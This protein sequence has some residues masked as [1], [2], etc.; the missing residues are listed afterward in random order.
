[1]FCH[2]VRKLWFQWCPRKTVVKLFQMLE[3]SVKRG[4][5][6]TLIHQATDCRLLIVSSELWSLCHPHW[7]EIRRASFRDIKPQDSNLEIWT[8]H[9]EHVNWKHL[10]TLD[11]S[12]CR[13]GFDGGN[14]NLLRAAAFKIDS[15][16]LAKPL[17][18]L[19]HSN[20]I[21]LWGWE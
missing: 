5:Q 21:Q 20:P 8:H 15:D 6:R 1:M 4:K 16:S 10:R 19:K 17:I 12:R 13:D 18:A 3:P 14:W 2:P 11:E 9:Q 7:M